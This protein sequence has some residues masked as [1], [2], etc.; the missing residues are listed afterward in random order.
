MEDIKA[1]TLN[2]NNEHIYYNISIAR[3]NK[4]NENIRAEFSETRTTPILNKGDDY[5]LAVV[6]FDLPTIDIPIFKWRNNEWKVSITY[7]TNVF[8]REVPFIQ[9]QNPNTT[10]KFFGDAVW[11]YQDY[12][13]CINLGLLQC[14]QDFQADP[15][16]LTIP[17]VDRPTEPP[18]MTYDAVSKRCN[19]F[20]PLE[21]DLTKPNP[22]YVYFNTLMFYF[23]PALQNYGDG[24]DPI[25]SFYLIVKDNKNNIVD[26]G[27]KQYIKLTEEWSELFLWND[28]QKILFETD[29]IPVNNE[30]ISGQKN[31]TR[32]VLTD[33]EPASGINDQSNIQ[34]F[35]RGDLRFYSLYSGLELRK[36]DMRVFWETKRGEV[37]PLFVS[38]NDKLTIKIYFKKKGTLISGLG[39]F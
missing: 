39:I 33:F 11:H 3:E 17:I 30:L 13:D 27:G 10:S 31:I 7:L 19:I 1:N 18:R 29:S 32:K 28:L 5:E 16:Y 26:V 14:F 2:D 21:Y 34:F 38:G 4:D 36:M 22:I 8:T 25:L 37:Y 24:R 12:I 9:N 35:P 6:R 15:V 23:F 20:Y